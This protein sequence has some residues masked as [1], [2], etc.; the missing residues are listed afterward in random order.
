MKKVLF[1]LSLLLSSAYMYA[2]ASIP[3]EI[4]TDTTAY[5]AYEGV[6]QL[7]ENGVLDTYTITTEGGKLYGQA[8][9]YDKTVLAKQADAHSFKSGYGSDVIFIQDAADKPIKKVKLVVQGNVV[10]GTKQ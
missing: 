9:G 7:D 4:T 2:N 6:Y 1:S 5:K 10:F 3:I 8:N